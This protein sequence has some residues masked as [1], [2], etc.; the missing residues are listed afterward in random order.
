MWGIKPD[1]STTVYASGFTNII[2]I[3]WGPKGS[4]YVL[5]ISANGLLS[6]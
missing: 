3:A 6:G 1:G 4:L 2:D 5:E